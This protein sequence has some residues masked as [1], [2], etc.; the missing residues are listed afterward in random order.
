MGLEGISIWQLLIIFLIV[1]LL[2]GSKRLGSLGEDLGSAIK[3][4]KKATIPVYEPD[5]FLKVLSAIEN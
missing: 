5:E 4:F 1:T 3:G 2:F